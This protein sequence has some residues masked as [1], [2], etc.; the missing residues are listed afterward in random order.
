MSEKD[1][2]EGQKKKLE[3]LCEEHNLTYSLKLDTYPVA[4]TLRPIQ[5]MYEQLSMLEAAEDGEMRISQDAYKTFCGG[6]ADYWVK[7]FGTF[8]MGTELE[9]KFL[10]IFKKIDIYWKHY[11]FRACIESGA[12]RKGM[13]PEID[14]DAE[15]TEPEG[16]TEDA[17]DL[18]NDV[19][20]EDETPDDELIEKATQLVR[21]ENKCTP[22]LLQRRLKLGYSKA[23]H[24]I[25][26][27]EMRGVVGQYRGSEPREV[28]P[29]DLPEDA[30]AAK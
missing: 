23:L 8:T 7:S 26:L 24:L 29:Y 2:F 12:L 16:P 27:L 1:K 20:P 28:L 3:N 11:F 15:D 4:M 5:G 10:N 25:D 6:N 30:E 17:E 14:E 13:M 21:M 9:R 22:S 19:G 18:E